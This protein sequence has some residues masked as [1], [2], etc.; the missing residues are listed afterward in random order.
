VREERFPWG[1]GAILVLLVVGG[2]GFWLGSSSV[3]P[4]I[5]PVAAPAAPV[6]P[7]APAYPTYVAPHGGGFPLIGL[8]FGLIVLVVV[9]KVVRHAAWAGNQRGP[10][11]GAGWG[12]PSWAA[13]S[14]G[15]GR[16][17]ARNE[18][19]SG[20]SRRRGSWAAG[21]V[22]PMVDEMFQRWH[23]RMHGQLTSEPGEP[24]ADRVADESHDRSADAKDADTPNDDPP[25]TLSV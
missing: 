14:G 4:V 2:I 20:W 5:V 19:P 8:F 3:A 11:F 18:P 21:D 13:G 25:S 10:G 6:V 24:A 22:P 9:V 17:S 1:L 23:S 16:G 7:T 12:G 15:Q